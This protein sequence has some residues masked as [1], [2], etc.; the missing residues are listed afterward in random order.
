M[1]LFAP[2]WYEYYNYPSD[3]S[4]TA[5]FLFGAF[6]TLLQSISV[7]NLKSTETK[8]QGTSERMSVI[9]ML[10]I[11][12]ETA[13]QAHQLALAGLIHSSVHQ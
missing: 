12:R 8:K 10:F 5:K 1:F 3:V 13:S 11:V 4:R 9:A 6:V 2:Q 7:R